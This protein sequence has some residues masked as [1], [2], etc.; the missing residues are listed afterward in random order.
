MV[1]EIESLEDFFCTAGVFEINGNLG[2]GKTILMALF[3]CNAHSYNLPVYSNFKLGSFSKPFD[4][5][6]D[7]KKA[8]SGLGLVEIDDIIAWMDSRMAMSHYKQTWAYQQSRKKE[9]VVTYSQ[10]SVTGADVRI[11]DLANAVIFTDIVNFPLF[12]L[13]FYTPSGEFLGDT[14]IEYD[15]SV[16]DLYDTYEIVSQKIA[17]EEI[18]DLK[19]RLDKRP[20]GYLVSIRY[21]VPISVANAIYDLIEDKDIDLA[22]EILEGYGFVIADGVV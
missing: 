14:Y 16:S 2:S 21:S 3:G 13:E 11:R 12:Y 4:T 17:R 6:T 1:D 9:K 20:F 15:K 10:Q 7:M 18:L 8:G 19:R 22:E 5:V